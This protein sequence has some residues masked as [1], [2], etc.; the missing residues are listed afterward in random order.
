MALETEIN[1]TVLQGNAATT[2]F[3]YL[4]IIPNADV[5]VATFTDSSGVQTVLSTSQYTIT[6]LDDPNGGT[7][8][9]PLVGSPMAVGESLTIERVV[10][11]T[12]PT[13]L[14]NQGAY[15]P[16]VVEGA[17]DWIVMQTQQLA[18][19]VSASIQF[20][21]VDPPANADGTLPA[22][23][24]R[25]NMTFA[26]DASGNPEMIDP[27]YGAL[28]S[29]AN[30]SF[31]QAGTGAVARS[32]QSKER[33]LVVGMDFGAAGDNSTTDTVSYQKALDSGALDITGQNVTGYK[34]GALTVPVGIKS[35]TGQRFYQAAADANLLTV[36]NSTRLR[37]TDSDFYGVTGT[38]A[39][40]SNSG[41]YLNTCANVQLSNLYFQNW[42]S[43]PLWSKAVTDSI[44]TNLLGK[45][46]SDGFRFT[47]CNNI[48]VAGAMLT[49]PQTPDATFVVAFGLD[50]T[51]GG[52]SV[53]TDITFSGC[54]VQ[55]YV[56]AQAYL[57]HAGNR[58][59]IS[60]GILDNVLIGVG[61]TQFNAADS[62]LDITVTGVDV[63]CTSSVGSVITSPVGITAFG[64]DNTFLAQNIAISSCNI[65]NANN[66]S[67]GTQSVD[68][69]AI[70][71]QYAKEVTLMG[72][73]ITGGAANGYAFYRRVQ[74]LTLIGGAI[75]DVVAYSGESNGMR[76]GENG[77]GWMAC[78]GMITGVKFR[79][80]T[81]GIRFTTITPAACT[82]ARTGATATLTKTAHGFLA[83]DW[84][85]VAGVDFSTASD[86]LYIGA[87]QVATVPTVDT[88]TYTMF[89]TPGTAAAPGSPTVAGT[90]DG[91]DIHDCSFE[92]VTTPITNA[93]YALCDGLRTYTAGDKAPWVG[94]NTSALMVANAAAVVITGLRGGI[95]GQ[96]V[97]LTFAD[98]NTTISRGSV[99]FTSA[100]GDITSAVGMS[101]TFVCTV[102]SPTAPVWKQLGPNATAT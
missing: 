58:V 27:T 54:N 88:L 6:G 75:S 9:Y 51:D 7:V 35:I 31:L 100:A 36:T 96:K 40:S 32:V 62:I 64:Y 43:Y 99:F 11:Y 37:I 95:V 52:N 77:G 67:A 57:I 82:I 5:V 70:E 42:R 20:P 8:T 12:Q 97:T 101:V 63:N 18:E 89:G 59:T 94:G 16:D 81:T 76:F 90:Y 69:G 72:N 13:V 23:Q 46:N 53:C 66:A 4:F 3:P 50:S 91:I 48:T 26:F 55:D 39:A 93:S 56:N 17:D 83:G 85:R 34:V 44:Y 22:W 28:T 19:R 61:I 45:G 10:P 68:R 14:T 74:D 29:A 49:A 2:V 92:G 79:N 86:G 71:V 30:V 1:K 80:V 60:G 25:A 38:V 73:N 21:P 41:I 78:N 102:A 15:Y 24:A 87:F 47:S 98:T 33:D 84:I 65:R